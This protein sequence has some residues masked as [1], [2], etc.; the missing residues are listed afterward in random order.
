MTTHTDTQ[1]KFRKWLPWGIAGILLAIILWPLGLSDVVGSSDHNDIVERKLL[2][3]QGIHEADCTFKERTDH[4]L[5]WNC[6]W[7]QDWYTGGTKVRSGVIS[8]TPGELEQHLQR[9]SSE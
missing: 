6:T 8:L 7:T 9:V 4:F 5:R 2:K 3:Q 1:G